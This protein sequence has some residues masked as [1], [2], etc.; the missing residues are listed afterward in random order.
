MD[1]AA[2]R[3]PEIARTWSG[4]AS[5]MSGS[6]RDGC[7]YFFECGGALRANLRFEKRRALCR[8]T[9][10]IVLGTVGVAPYRII[11]RAVDGVQNDFLRDRGAFRP[12]SRAA[13]RNDSTPHD[14][15]Q[16]SKGGTGASVGEPR[17]GQRRRC[18]LQYASGGRTVLLDWNMNPL[19]TFEHTLRSQLIEQRSDRALH[20][21]LLLR[22]GRSIPSGHGG[23][24]GVSHEGF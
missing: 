18:G 4:L 1:E 22:G 15:V 19:R 2:R 21:V 7:F 24:G 8:K 14:H 10:G 5:T 11:E 6:A 17:H 16:L 12:A 20:S 13:S 23:F 3:L 9:S